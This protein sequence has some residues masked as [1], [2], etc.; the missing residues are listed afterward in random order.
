M[1]PQ[2]DTSTFISQIFW[3]FI[4]FS[5]LI[6]FC[7]FFYFPKFY[8]LVKKRS[9]HIEK[10]KM[11]VKDYEKELE[12]LI[13]K[14]EEI[15]E[16]TKNELLFLKRDLTKRQQEELIIYEKQLEENLKSTLLSFKD[17][18]QEKKTFISEKV[19]ERMLPIIIKKDPSI[20]IKPSS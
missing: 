2:F 8:A 19:L 1:M 18:L 20:F 9:L 12:V 13:R 10:E 4:S 17:S 14:K 7:R 11:A 3:L 6:L 15:M 5:L 16:K